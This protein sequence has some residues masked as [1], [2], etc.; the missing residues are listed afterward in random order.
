MNN[1]TQAIASWLGAVSSGMSGGALDDLGLTLAEYVL[2]GDAVG[3]L[4]EWFAQLDEARRVDVQAAVIETCIFMAHVDRDLHP[5]ERA[6]IEETIHRSAL[7]PATR[8]E[9]RERVFEAGAP[10]RL[11]ERLGHP[12]LR[13]LALALAWELVLADDRVRIEEYEGHVW[14]SE[15]LGVPPDRVAALRD[16]ISLRI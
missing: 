6:L 9:L 4:S 1:A 11:A 12:V 7:D 8:A 3:A 14:L 16:A 5:A 15:Q 13:E 10:P 2:G